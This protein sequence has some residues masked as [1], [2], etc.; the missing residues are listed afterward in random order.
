VLYRL[1]QSLGRLGCVLCL[2]QCCA[3]VVVDVVVVVAIYWG[4]WAM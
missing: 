4:D 2:F 1:L 3:L